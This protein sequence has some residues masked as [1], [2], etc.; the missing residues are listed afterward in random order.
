M[1]NQTITA[2]TTVAALVGLGLADGQNI[3]IN[4][5][6]VLTMSASPAVMIGQ[7]TINDGKLL[8]DG[9]SAT[10]PIVWV[11]ED[12]EEVNVNGAGTLETTLGWWECPTTSTGAINQ[13]F[14]IST[15]F[16]AAAIDADVFAGCWVE[17]G[18]RINYDGGSGVL[19][20][21]G[22]WVFATS[23][24]DIHGRIT[25]VVGDAVSGYFVVR[26]LTGALADNDAI[27]LHTI[28]DNK[29]VDYVKSWNGLANGVDVLESGTFQ[30][31]G[32]AFQNGSNHLADNDVGSGMA[33][34][35]FAQQFQN[36]NL[37]FGD[38]TNGFIPPNG[39]R[40][41]IPMIHIA[42]SDVT[43]IATN[44]SGLLS[45]G[46]A[47][48]E[49]E[50]VN[51][52]DCFLS[53]V[54]LGSAYWED[55][56]GG[57]F[58]ASYC[59]AFINLGVYAALG[60]P[61]YNHC[62]FCSDSQDDLRS[63]ARS[64]PPIVDLVSGADV[65]DCLYVSLNDAAETTGF[66]GQTS[67]DVTITRC[68]QLALGNANEAE[69]LRID[70][71]VID[72]FVVLGTQLVFNGAVNVDARLLK[73]Q[74]N[75]TGGVAGSDQIVLS[76]SSKTVKIVGW[77]VLQG[78]RP[79]DSM[80]AITDSSDVK[81]YGFHFI[82]DKFDNEGLGGTQG[83]EFASIAGFCS[84]I[85][86][87]RCWTNRGNPNEF[88][89]VASGTTK[90][91]TVLNCSAEYSG[92]L[93]PDG[94]NTSF[95]GIHGG[96]GS[97]GGSSGLETDYPGTAGGHFGDAFES[98]TKGYIYYRNVPGTIEYPITILSG[99]PKFTKDGDVDVV[100]GDQWEVDMGYVALGHT[101][102]SGVV[103]TTRNALTAA[104]GV[105]NWTGVDIDF[106]Y[107]T[108]AGY[109]GTWLDLRTAGN[110]TAITDTT[111][112]VRLKLRFTGNATQSNGQA[113]T[114]HTTTT[115]ADQVANYHSISEIVTISI[116]GL[117]VGAELRIYDDDGDGIY[118]TYGSN[119]EGVE[120]LGADSYDFTHSADEAG[121][122]IWVQVMSDSTVEQNAKITLGTSDQTLQFTL[123]LEENI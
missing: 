91:L 49:L 65:A 116:Q 42:T 108:G 81:I 32:N 106:Q 86:I 102:F 115:I 63:A 54:S 25:E 26:F 96:S 72:D 93:E 87:A 92:E 55:N 39:A 76:G 10:D 121:G 113:L 35:V 33:G 37:S 17:T 111:D 15:Y 22:D 38:G 85:T 122:I 28:Q 101:G 4:N 57:E 123:Q 97:L 14:D 94:I 6:A 98:D 79:D 103:T 99:A 66:G 83:E 27:E 29:G 34:F 3:T 36:A 1:A 75:L 70:G 44:D 20:L 107:D 62:I 9:A 77:E 50:T 67:I 31:F 68:I 43:L 104:E 100:L 110:L 40:I 105:D 48:Y 89:L 45:S 59:A 74:K 82:D 109:N 5:G 51:G 114:I 58:Q 21:V 16:T 7:V 112:G 23:D 11:G 95:R 73:T 19:P 78:S 52:G 46:T 90:N 41:R 13:N 12:S 30:E 120:T 88:A 84:D 118:N 80:I 24:N 18:R 64:V 69:A 119:R 2:D 60:R 71:I 56:L 47:R 117:V 53:G 61:T 8:V